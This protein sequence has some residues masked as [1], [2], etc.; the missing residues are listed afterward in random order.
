M[1]DFFDGGAMEGLQYRLLC[2]EALAG[3]ANGT[4]VLKSDI[5]GRRIDSTGK[6]Q[7]LVSWNPPDM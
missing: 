1:F 3:G 4:V 5:R 7:V 6:A 2:T